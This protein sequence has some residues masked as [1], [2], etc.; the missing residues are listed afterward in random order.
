MGRRLKVLT[1][2]CKANFADSASITGA[3][4][5]AGHAVVPADAPADV[6]VVNGCTVTHRAD[7]DSRALVRRARREN[8][9][10]TVI[11]TGCYAE[12]A[13][14]GRTGLPEADLWI[15]TGEPSVLATVLRDLGGGG[16]VRPPPSDFAAGLLLGH[17]RTVLK[18]QDGCDS[19][20]AYCIVPLARGR[21][22]SL[23]PETVLAR[24]AWAE[25]D[26]GREIV[27]AGIHVGL[28]G[29]DRGETDGLARLVETILAKT[30]KVRVRLSSIEP[31]EVS[32]RL[33]AV[34]A[35]SDRV[36]PHFH[37]PL[38]SGCDRTLA[39]MRRSY[40]AA[41][42]RKVVAKA[43]SLIPGLQVG[44]DVIAGFP[45]ETRADF[46]ETVRFLQDAPVHYLHV[47]PYS[48]R[49]GTESA[50][51]RDDVSGREKKERAA[52]LRELDA[53]KRVAFRRSQVGR[54]LDV[55]AEEVCVDAETLSGYSGNYLTVTF[56]GGHADVGEIHRVCVHS[57]SD[58]GLEGR[59]DG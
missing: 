42:Y 14:S 47:F 11:V 55:L 41:E 13:G 46:E 39:R 28:Y 58:G 43:A 16:A 29:A 56:P 52:L 22:R 59:R 4:V 25:E 54:E 32:D 33:L 40:T 18:I 38:Q 15:G 7:R 26:G 49:K 2:G 6:V 53:A 51:W 1:V 31:P 34:V 9:A 24:A 50:L 21:N 44:A 45:G 27:L 5:V 17:R 35:G 20:C 57:V 10:A 37:V 36:C 12:T 8:P 23:Q 48:Q 30:A 3:A 19:Q